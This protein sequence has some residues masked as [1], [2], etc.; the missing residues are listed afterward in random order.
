[1]NPHSEGNAE[2]PTEQQRN[3]K[4]EVQILPGLLEAVNNIMI[5][6]KEKKRMKKLLE[7]Y[8]R[9]NK[10]LKGETK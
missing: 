5:T 2:L 8:R 1:M 4:A 3:P 6:E 10:K 9:E 7:I